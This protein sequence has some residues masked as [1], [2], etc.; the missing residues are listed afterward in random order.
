MN[1]EFWNFWNFWNFWKK[2]F[3]CNSIMKNKFATN[4]CFKMAF[5]DI[6]GGFYPPRVFEYLEG[7]LQNARIAGLAIGIARMGGDGSF[8]LRYSCHA[9]DQMMIQ[10]RIRGWL[11]NMSNDVAAGVDDDQ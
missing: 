3:F 7:N 11:D 9:A 10:N 4:P 6:A 2:L 5:V 1:L 8:Q